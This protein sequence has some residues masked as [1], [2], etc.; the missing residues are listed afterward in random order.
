MEDRNQLLH[1]ILQ[2]IGQ[3]EA[4]VRIIRQLVTQ[5]AKTNVEGNQDIIFVDAK[6]VAP[7]VDAQHQ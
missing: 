5:L 4:K 7:V 6:L 1:C 2:H 3:I